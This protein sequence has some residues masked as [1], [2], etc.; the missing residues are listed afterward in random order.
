MSR[1]RPLAASLL[2]LSAVATALAIR[3]DAREDSR[4]AR[5]DNGRLAKVL[6]DRL[7]D[8][9]DVLSGQVE[10]RPE[11]PRSIHVELG[12]EGVE[13]KGRGSHRC[14]VTTYDFASP[15]HGPIEFVYE[16]TRDGSCWDA[17]QVGVDLADGRGRR[18]PGPGTLGVTDVCGVIH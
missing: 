6:N 13:C 7:S 17:R 10:S 1:L 9:E 11:W 3:S 12:I 15:S 5:H 16:F 4:A 2:L 14:T 18:D 8:H